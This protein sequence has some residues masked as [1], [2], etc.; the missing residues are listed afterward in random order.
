[1]TRL[2]TL[3]CLILGSYSLFAQEYLTGIQERILDARD[4]SFQLGENEVL[5]VVEELDIEFRKDGSSTTAYWM[6]YG[7]YQEVIFYMS[8]DQKEQAKARLTETID[9]LEGLKQAASEKHALL[10]VLYSLAINFE[11]N[12][13]VPYSNKADR[14]YN[15]AIKLDADNLRAWMGLGRSDYYTPKAYGGGQEVEKCL[16]KAIG[17]PDQSAAYDHAPTWGKDE[18]YLYLAMYYQ[19][20]GHYENAILYCKQGLRKFPD[21]YRLGELMAQLEGR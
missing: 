18:A 21:H 10:G 20:E 17:L 3:T 15:K 19:R 6:S 14:H 12:M 7:M 11:P 13:A 5:P 16:T 1:M 2:F 8:I 4:A 9:Q